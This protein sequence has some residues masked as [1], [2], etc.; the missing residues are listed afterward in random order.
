MFQEF[1]TKILP[2]VPEA[3]L[4]FLSDYC[5]DHESITHYNGI[6]NKELAELYQKSWV[7]AYPSV[8]EGFG[9]VYTEALACGAVI[10][11]SDNIGA[12]DILGKDKLGVIATDHSFSE[13]ITTSS[14]TK[15]VDIHSKF[16]K[17]YCEDGI[18][19]FV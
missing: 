14:N 17:E 10:V 19:I 15:H 7:M 16:V 1:V 5:P 12:R 11:T 8:Y 18:I 6:T 2:Q 13:N 4:L 9:M 3:Q